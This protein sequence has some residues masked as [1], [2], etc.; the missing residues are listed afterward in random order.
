MTGEKILFDKFVFPI[1]KGLEYLRDE[2]NS[3]T[4]Y[5]FVN[6]P[7]DS[8][9][10]YFENG[11]ERF[12]PPDDSMERG[13]CFFELKRPNRKISFFCPERQG[14]LPSAMWYFYVELRD[15]QGR[16]HGLPGQVR[17]MLDAPCLRVLQPKPLFL[18]VLETVALAAE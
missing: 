18:E 9:S 8:F 17:V 11:M 10:M 1:M 14:N 12:R 6:R 16:A 3:V 7:D 2:E 15:G 13:Y 5:L 4:D